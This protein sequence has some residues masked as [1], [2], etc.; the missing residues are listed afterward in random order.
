MEA[1]KKNFF[2]FGDTAQ[3]LY[4]ERKLG[5]TVELE[6]IRDLCDKENKPKFFELYRNYRLPKTVARF[7]Q[8]VGVDLP[9]FNEQ[10]YRST[11]NQIPRLIQY[12]QVQEQCEAIVRIIHNHRLKDVAILL[13]NNDVVPSVTQVLKGLDLGLEMKY[14]NKQDWKQNVESLDF[15][16]DNPKVM[17]YHSAKG[18]QFETVFLPCLESCF[19]DSTEGRRALYVA[20]TRTYRSLYMM[21][22][23]TM[24]SL[25]ASIPSNLYKTSEIDE[26]EDI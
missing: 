7:V 23:G 11:E 6:D 1:T 21:Y 4:H 15:T 17:T 18:L 13:P 16:T 24:P 8:H 19:L 3:S 10:V 12:M 14:N 2:F 9:T 26:I 20:M 25:L 5:G 22:S